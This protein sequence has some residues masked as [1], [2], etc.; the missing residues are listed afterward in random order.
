MTGVAVATGS[1]EQHRRP[2]PPRQLRAVPAATA[3]EFLLY[4]VVALLLLWP[5]T[6]HLTTRF[7]GEGDAR[8]YGWVGW[9]IGQLI[10]TGDVFSLHVPDVLW[11]FGLNLRL[12]DGVGPSLLAGALNAI[13]GV[14]TAYNLTFVIAALLNMWAARHLARLLT[15]HRPVWIVAAIAFATAPCVALHAQLG[16][17]TLYFGFPI[18][19]L[20]AEAITISR[21]D[22]TT[23]WI[24]LGLLLA[25]SFACSVYFAIFGALVFLLIILA[26]RRSLLT[27]RLLARIGGGVLFA[28]LLLLPLALPRLSFEHA[29]QRAGAPASLERDALAFSPDLLSIVAQP[30]RST[31]RVP[32]HRLTDRGLLRL[33]IP[34][35]SGEVTV[36]PGLILLAAIVG[37]ALQRSRWRRPF[38]VAFGV[39][40]VLTLGLVLEVSGHRISNWMPYRMLLGLPGLGSLRG[41]DR[42]SMALAAV[43][44]GALIVCLDRLYSRAVTPRAKTLVLGGC[45]ALLATNLLLPVPSSTFG[46]SSQAQSALAKIDQTRR[47]GDTVLAVPDDC[48]SNAFEVAI[49]QVYHRAPAVG[50]TG[51]WAA[52]PWFASLRN[53][54][55]NPGFNALRCDTHLY[56]PLH[57]IG[58]RSAMT[59]SALSSLRRHFGVRYLLVFRG[60]LLPPAC[61]PVLAALKAIPVSRTLGGDKELEVLDLGE[62][63]GRAT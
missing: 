23:S 52:T 32:W 61:G 41:P 59:P 31:I 5:A 22:R 35:Y 25:V 24:R 58:R 2:E 40:W 37:L 9:R 39:I 13:F 27:W 10:H 36:Y 63:N 8:H 43:A 26:S 12:L 51:T 4:L 16:L 34:D 45:V 38:L 1:D 54:V 57:T 60:D 50:C 28:G 55:R 15:P 6:L 46:V 11:P 48:A 42:G 21:G 47:P 62:S 56:G 29:E 33:P 18:L 19:L 7:V 53:Y 14:Y 49:F 44:T 17:Q 30:T 3:A 20:T